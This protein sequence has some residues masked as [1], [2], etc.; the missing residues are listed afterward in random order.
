MFTAKFNRHTGTF[1]RADATGRARLPRM[2][3]YRR[4]ARS[5]SLL[6]RSKCLAMLDT[7]EPTAGGR[8]KVDFELTTL[9]GR[10]G[11][12]LSLG[13]SRIVGFDRAFEPLAPA[14]VIL[15]PGGGGEDLPA[16]SGASGFVR[17]NDLLSGEVRRDALRESGWLPTGIRLPR[18][19]CPAARFVRYFGATLAA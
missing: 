10:R 2:I 13:P 17:E 6:I 19:A 3:A 9:A 14:G 1:A 15:L 8:L 18:L 12:A 4:L 16:R 11:G 7:F 5:F